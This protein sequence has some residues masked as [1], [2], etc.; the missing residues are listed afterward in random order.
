MSQPCF[1]HYTPP[2]LLSFPEALMNLDLGL[3]QD[4]H[5]F[6][7]LRSVENIKPQAY[8]TAIIKL[9]RRNAL[10]NPVRSE[11]RLR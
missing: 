5:A 2:A 11:R 7:L 9:S 8:A 4:G 3:A 10:G 6:A 1:M